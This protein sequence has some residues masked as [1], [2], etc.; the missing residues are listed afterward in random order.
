[1]P[2]YRI[3]LDLVDLYPELDS[4]GLR[5][6]NSPFLL[7]ILESEN[8]DQACYEIMIRLMRSLIRQNNDIETRIFCRKVRRLMRVDKVEC[9]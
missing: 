9:L 3:S 1:M 4:Y 2:N 8:A 6:F 5:E 7:Y